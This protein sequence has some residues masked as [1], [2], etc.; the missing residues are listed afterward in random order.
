MSWLKWFSSKKIRPIV[1]R[2]ISEETQVDIDVVDISILSLILRGDQTLIMI[3]QYL[4][5]WCELTSAAPFQAPGLVKQRSWD[6]L[7]EREEATFEIDTVLNVG[8]NLQERQ[9]RLM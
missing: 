3:N 4:L 2:S 1:P 8:R 6:C 9:T 7:V 5:V